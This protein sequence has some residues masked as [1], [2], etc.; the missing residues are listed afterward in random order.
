MGHINHIYTITNQLCI[1]F[2]IA[3]GS[4]RS[5]S[6]LNKHETGVWS[7][8]SRIGFPLVGV[9]SMI[10]VMGIIDFVLCTL[11][12]NIIAKKDGDNTCTMSR[13]ILELLRRP[14]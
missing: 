10:C 11:T 4:L 9:R 2:R 12:I 14:F 1:S 5:D 3:S 7:N 8:S 13:L 6:R